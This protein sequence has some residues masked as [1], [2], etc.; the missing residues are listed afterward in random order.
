[1]SGPQN[2]RKSDCWL[3]PHAWRFVTAVPGTRCGCRNRLLCSQP[4]NPRERTYVTL[5]FLL[6]LVT[7]TLSFRSGSHSPGEGC[8]AI[9]LKLPLAQKRASIT[10]GVLSPT[11]GGQ[12]CCWAACADLPGA[13]RLDYCSFSVHARRHLER[14]LDRKH[15]FLPFW[16]MVF[17]KATGLPRH[18][19][20]HHRRE[21]AFPQTGDA[22]RR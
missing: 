10:L 16:H 6:S 1:M 20:S 14:L 5:A 7:G 13:L 3:T 18:P 12:P 11:P 15:T 21:A 9:C 17:C 8:D 2:Y 4:G 19:R 22:A